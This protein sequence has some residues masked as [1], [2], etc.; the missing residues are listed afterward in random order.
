MLNGVAGLRDL[1]RE[2][3]S[4]T[5]MLQRAVAVVT[6]AL[7]GC[8]CRRH[9]HSAPSGLSGVKKPT[10]LLCHTTR[11]YSREGVSIKVR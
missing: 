4:T 6:Y 5:H 3:L 1:D 7:T 11:I 8:D 2:R 10:Q 9:G